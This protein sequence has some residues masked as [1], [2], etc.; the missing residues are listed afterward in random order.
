MPKVTSRA[1]K[2]SVTRCTTNASSSTA[3]RATQTIAS[4]T[5]TQKLIPAWW[6]NA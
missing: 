3:N 1:A 4:T 5:P 6:M 2:W